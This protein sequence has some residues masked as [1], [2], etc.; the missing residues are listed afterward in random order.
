MS[1][2][3]LYAGR[4]PPAGATNLE[5]VPRTRRILVALA[6]AA[7]VVGLASCSST[8]SLTPAPS[9]NAPLCAEVSVR[10]P[11]TVDGLARRWT[12]AQATGAWGSPTSAVILTCGVEP[13]GPTT[14]D[15]GTIDGID[16]L[17]DDSKAPNYLFTTYGRT[18]AVQVYLDY[19]RV[20][21]GDVLRELAPAVSRLPVDG[22]C[23]ARSGDQ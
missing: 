17:I 7:S 8:V 19:D 10:L 23:T 15:C 16:W 22:K 20:S 11:Q 14:Q 9:A 21:S 13:P 1:T 18:P 3:P 4:S 6:V 12:D 2:P 5:G